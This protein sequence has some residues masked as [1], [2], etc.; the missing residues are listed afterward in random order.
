MT[1]KAFLFCLCFLLAQQLAA[2]FPIGQISTT[3]TDPT[4][5]NRQIPVEIFYPATDTGVNMDVASG[6]FPVIVIGH[7]FTMTFDAY[8]NFWNELVPQG[9]I[10]IIPKTE[11]GPIPFPSH[12][13]FANDLNYCLTHL[14]AE[15]GNTASPFFGKVIDRTI[16]MGLSMGGGCSLLAAEQ[17]P[18]VTALV[19][20]APGETTPSAIAAAA[21]V[22]IA[23]LVLAGS[24]DAVTPAAE[25]SDPM[26][27]ALTGSCKTL[28]TITDGS[29]CGFSESSTL[30]DI[31]ENS[32]CPGCTF[33]SIP[34]QH[35]IMFRF[36]NP[37]LGGILKDAGQFIAFENQLVVDTSIT[38]THE[39]ISVSAPEVE[40]S[41][42]ITIAPNPTTGII[43]LNKIATI[44]LF[45]KQGRQILQT[46]ANHLDISALPA[47]IYFLQGVHDKD[48]FYHRVIKY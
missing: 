7:G 33:I 3:L 24:K 13:E 4:R 2:Q 8:E 16:M 44:N 37:W 9:Y 35:A 15:N 11:T 28:I 39:C 36:L 29:H 31:G 6:Q 32:A 21:E 42:E 25:D 10:L 18:N 45:D 5:S 1:P 20:L 26:F 38:Y 23:T 14:Q 17:N 41:E 40:G 46:T 48:V 12:T 47:G 19:L 34:E 30:C 27:A 43:L 22:S